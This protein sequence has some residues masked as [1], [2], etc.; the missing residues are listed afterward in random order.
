MTP[1][2]QKLAKTKQ[3]V[4]VCRGGRR[5]PKV[6]APLVPPEVLER[7]G[8]QAGMATDLLKAH[9]EAVMRRVSHDGAMASALGRV[10]W[11]FDRSGR[12]RRRMMA[13]GPQAGREP[14][15]T[16]AMEWAAVTYQR[17][18]FSW[19][20]AVGM[21]RRSAQAFDPELIKVDGGG[22]PMFEVPTGQSPEDV[23][24]VAEIA[25]ARLKLAS[26]AL[27]RCPA[28]ALVDAVIET[29]LVD[30]YLPP[31]LLER[32]QALEALRVGLNALDAVLV[33]KG[34]RHPRIRA[35]TFPSREEGGHPR[36]AASQRR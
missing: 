5:K 36:A 8:E 25:T 15:I 2:T 20:A 17:L 6:V 33:Q 35:Q 4:R 10:M 14:L 22:Y 11:S 7:R 13:F 24:R 23:E 30:D 32:P 9:N 3:T 34:P 27:H 16:D 28:P 18:W 21:P 29:V 19:S 31:L 26:E 1:S 12:R